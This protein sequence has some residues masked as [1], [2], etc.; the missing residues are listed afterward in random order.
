MESA[1]AHP[2]SESAVPSQLNPQQSLSPSWGSKAMG[3][4]NRSRVMP[5][6]S[7]TAD[8]LNYLGGKY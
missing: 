4:M 8:V 5:I 6:M 2:N 7:P 3:I 1:Q